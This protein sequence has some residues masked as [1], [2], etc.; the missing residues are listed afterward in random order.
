MAY[1]LLPH[2]GKQPGGIAPRR[3]AK[4]SQQ[5]RGENELM[6]LPDMMLIPRKSAL[7]CPAEF[8]SR[9]EVLQGF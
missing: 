9:F 5:A 8:A 1:G 2:P 3:A 4:Q 6:G 7:A